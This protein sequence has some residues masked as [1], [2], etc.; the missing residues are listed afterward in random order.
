MIAVGSRLDT[1]EVG[2]PFAH[3]ARGSRKVVVDI[4]PAEIAKFRRYG[5]DV[6]IP[7]A[8]NAKHFLEALD[9]RLPASG[10]DISAWQQWI[11]DKRSRYPIVHASYRRQRTV[12]PYV[13]VDALA[14]AAK[15]DDTIVVDTGCAVAWMSQAFRFKEGQ[16]YFH[17][18][19]NTP[20]GY[21]LP[22][23]IGASFALG[24]KRV[25]C[26]T[27]DGALQINIQELATVIRHQLPI[28]IFLLNNHGY[29][30]IQQTQD[31][32]LNSHYIASSV[33]GGLAFPDFAKVAAAYGFKTW[34]LAANANVAAVDEIL[35]ETGP[36]FVNVELR[37][38][39]RVIPQVRFGRPIE[40]GEPLLD[41]QE[42]FANM[43]VEPVEA[44]RK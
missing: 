41:R 38:E 28:T 4:D 40:D 39:E 5:M 33:E 9:A 24:K 21:S 31:Q 2:S 43:L 12:N 23:A 30:M 18:F 42:F 25:I 26:V 34:T 35:R 14:Q 22:A 29:S 13:F 6:D 16:R 8:A 17:A 37:P 36:V 27:G 44:S 32:W 1:H 7:V 19:N 11:E 10:R 3:F 20:M 15:P